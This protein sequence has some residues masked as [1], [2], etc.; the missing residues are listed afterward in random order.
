MAPSKDPTDFSNLRT[1][2]PINTD[3]NASPVTTS[4]K[5]K[6]NVDM[7]IEV[8]KNRPIGEIVCLKEAMIFGKRN[9]FDQIID[10]FVLFFCSRNTRFIFL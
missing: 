8:S 5:L 6:R 2:E 9:S 7:F 1:I 3:P 10:C 4:E